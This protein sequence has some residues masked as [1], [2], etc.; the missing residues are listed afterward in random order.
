MNP[1]GGFTS[2]VRN[3]LRC[4]FE[5]KEHHYLALTV[6][7][8]SSKDGSGSDKRMADLQIC[9]RSVLCNITMGSF[10]ELVSSLFKKWSGAVKD[11][12]SSCLTGLTGHRQAIYC[13]QNL[14]SNYFWKHDDSIVQ[15]S[16]KAFFQT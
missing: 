3:T 4:F 1:H 12:V 8:T 9:C 2:C 10:P 5:Q 6:V 13:Q 16:Q 7:L 14:I 15:R 11:G